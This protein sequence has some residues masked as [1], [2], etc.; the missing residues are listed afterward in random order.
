MYGGGLTEKKTHRGGEGSMAD[1]EMTGT[2]NLCCG[3][4]GRWAEVEG[5]NDRYGGSTVRS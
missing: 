4:V 1:L 5:D 3:G 2:A